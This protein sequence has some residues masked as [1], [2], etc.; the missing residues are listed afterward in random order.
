MIYSSYLRGFGGKPKSEDS[1]L[2]SYE[3]SSMGNRFSTFRENVI[4]SSLG[5][6]LSILL[7]H[8]NTCRCGH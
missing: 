4:F 7:G 8:F 5:E 1:V 6:E 2:P 3:A